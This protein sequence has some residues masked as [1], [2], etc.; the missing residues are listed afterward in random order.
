MTWPYYTKRGSTGGSA[1]GAFFLFVFSLSFWGD[2][3][4][5]GEWWLMIW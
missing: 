2:G 4:D 1:K 5:D 3:D